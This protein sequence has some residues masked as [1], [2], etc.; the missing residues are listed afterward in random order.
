MKPDQGLTQVL[1]ISVLSSAAMMAIAQPVFAAAQV[2]AVQLTPTAGG[3]TLVLR[4]NGS[5]RP[6]VFSVN[7]GRTWTAD[8]INTQLAMPGGRFQQ[9]NPAP[10]FL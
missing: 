2:T 7:R 1:M 4:T 6:Q 8:L 9:A 5:D 3:A 10:E